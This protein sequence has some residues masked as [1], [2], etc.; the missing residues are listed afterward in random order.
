MGDLLPDGTWTGV[1]GS[2]RR[3]EVDVGKLS[4]LQKKNMH[5]IWK[6]YVSGVGAFKMTP[7]RFQVISFSKPII[8]LY[9][10][11]FIERPTASH[12]L[13]YLKPMTLLTWI[14][15]LAFCLVS[16]IFLCLTAR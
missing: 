14:S 4:S 10:E 15:V 6:K 7:E 9:H 16:P 13:D 2:L 3:K 1:I 11:F 5:K 8:R 12:K